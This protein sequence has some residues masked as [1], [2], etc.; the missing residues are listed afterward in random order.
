[1]RRTIGRA[2]SGLAGAGLLAL[3]SPSAAL[4][5]DVP[6]FG[7]P[8]GVKAQVV[9]AFSMKITGA[10]KKDVTGKKGDGK[11]GLIGQCNP[12]SWANFGVQVGTAMGTEQAGIAVI[13]RDK[14]AT[15]ATGT[16]PLDKVY[17][18]WFSMEGGTISAPRYGGPG[19]LTITTHDG[20]AGHRRMIGA[21][22]GTGL[23]GL[24]GD[25]KGK[26][27]DVE[28]SFDMDFSCGVL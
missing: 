12:A 16:F 1:M 6:P 23:A 20:S 8:L 22:K 13:T 15:G 19:V 7:P 25:A 4:A 21:I 28:A 3:A 27:I 26:K 5:E 10:V 11:T 18:D 9:R 2:L 17:V 14:I 24:D